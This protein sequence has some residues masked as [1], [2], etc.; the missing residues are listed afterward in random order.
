MVKD[1]W[2][3]AAENNM[4]QCGRVIVHA[5]SLNF[6]YFSFFCIVFFLRYYL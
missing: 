6:Y 3:I 5:V 2:P 1:P 4:F